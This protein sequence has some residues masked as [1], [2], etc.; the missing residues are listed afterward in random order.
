MI[1]GELSF[2]LCPKVI[3]KPFAH[4]FQE[5]KQ[6]VTIVL[7]R[8]ASYRVLSLLHQGDGC[9]E[10]SQSLRQSSPKGTRLSTVQV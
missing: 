8:L 10:R 2:V 7:Q 1:P 4:E 5:H 9:G 3:R 6:R